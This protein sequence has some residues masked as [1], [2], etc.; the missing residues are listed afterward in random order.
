MDLGDGR[1]QFLVTA[2]HILLDGWSRALLIGELFELYGLLRAGSDERA[3]PAVTPYRDYLAW[4]DAQDRTAAEDAW[5]RVLDGVD[6]PT[7]LAAP[8]AA[9]EPLAP[10]LTRVELPA[11]ATAEL[12]R[13]A[14]G[15][16]ITVNTVVQAAWAI[17]L[18]RLTGRDDVVF[19]G[20]VSGRPPQLP[21]VES[22]I[23][24]FINTLPVRVALNPAEPLGDLLERLQD[25][26]AA[27][28]DHQFLGL[29][30]IQRLTPATGELFDTLL[31][32][33]N[34]PVDTEGLRRS[35]RRPRRG[36]RP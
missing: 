35:M 17:V 18:G 30:D 15:R 28:M 26:Q 1:Y 34:Y 4:V 7:L 6:E 22:M 24:L 16:G 36:R 19:G 10:A 25:Q 31:V 13:W 33:E 27:L 9:R 11:A 2:H 5:R 21:G 29:G 32:F 14:R 20:T 3:L 12:T 8:A 23:G